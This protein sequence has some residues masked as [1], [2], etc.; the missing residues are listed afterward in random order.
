MAPEHITVV[1]QHQL[2]NCVRDRRGLDDEKLV[3]SIHSNFLI[4]DRSNVHD[5][6]TDTE[7]FTWWS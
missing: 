1:V 7:G 3:T 2:L 5:T 6:D 4:L